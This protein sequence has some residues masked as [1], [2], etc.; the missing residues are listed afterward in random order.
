VRSA[1]RRRLSVGRNL[2]GIQ[3]Y[4]FSVRL[5]ERFSKRSRYTTRQRERLWRARWRMGAGQRRHACTGFRSDDQNLWMVL[6]GVT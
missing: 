2:V 3:R 6:G 4:V 1:V 5:A